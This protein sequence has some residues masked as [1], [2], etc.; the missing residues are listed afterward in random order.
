MSDCQG[1]GWGPRH[2]V[3]RGT[4]GG[5][6]PQY[7]QNKNVGVYAD[8]NLRRACSPGIGNTGGKNRIRAA[9]MCAC[10]CVCRCRCEV[11]VG[12]GDRYGDLPS[13]EAKHG[14]CWRRGH[15]SGEPRDTGASPKINRGLRPARRHRSIFSA[16]FAARVLHFPSGLLRPFSGP[17]KW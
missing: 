3:G 6:A 12:H 7:C 5:L 11:K 14:E 10:R 13:A 9:C 8:K 16:R 1:P 17:P 4:D 2:G 15:L